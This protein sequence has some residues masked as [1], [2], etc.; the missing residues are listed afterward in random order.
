M[1]MVSIKSEIV[2]GIT[3]F[4]FAKSLFSWSLFISV[5]ASFGQA[6]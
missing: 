6:G 4:L 2:K 5:A 1:K 3:Y